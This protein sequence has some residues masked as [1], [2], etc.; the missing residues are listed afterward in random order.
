MKSGKNK[1]VQSSSITMPLIQD[2]IDR[3]K[4]DSAKENPSIG[5]EP[6]PAASLYQDAG[7]GYN[8]DFTFPQD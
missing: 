6:L 1:T 5:S 3:A 8:S 7:S 4:C 2:L